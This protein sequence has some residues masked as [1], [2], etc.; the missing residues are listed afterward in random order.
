MN[1]LLRSRLGAQMLRFAIVGIGSTL[2]S[3]VI[4]IGFVQVTTHQWA[5]VISLVLS[6]LVNTAINRRFTFG[7]AGRQGSTR[8]QLKSLVLV[9]VTWALTAGSLWA[10]AHLAPTAT[11]AA[12]VVAFLLGNVVATIVRFFLLRRWFGVANHPADPEH[13]RAEGYL[14]SLPL[15]AHWESHPSAP[16]Q[17]TTKPPG[18]GGPGGSVT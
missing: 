18:P 2:L 6:T 9:L 12:A 14:E 7:V 11:T 8:V 17:E 13:P 3:V 16:E 5:N 10:L 4:F 15:A 1:D